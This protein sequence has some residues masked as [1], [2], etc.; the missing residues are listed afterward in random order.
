MNITNPYR[1]TGANAGPMLGRENTFRAIV[2]HLTKAT[3]DHLSVVGP[4]RYGKTVILRELART[5]AVSNEHYLAAAYMDLRHGTPQSDADF[6]KRLAQSVKE[7]LLNSRGDLVEYLVDDDDSLGELLQY[8]FEELQKSSS[9]L[10]LVMDGFDYL[11]LGDGI[12]PNLLDQMRAFAQMSSVRLVTGSRDRLREL[13]KTE[14]SRTSEFWRIFYDPP[15]EIGCLEERDWEHFLGSFGSRGIKIQ[16][17]AL[18]ELTNWSGGIPVLAGMLAD[19]LFEM[20]AEGREVSPDDVNRV[21]ADVLETRNDHIADLWDDCSADIQGFV[22]DLAHSDILASECVPHQRR[23]LL[24]RGFAQETSGKLKLSS[25]LIGEYSKLQGGGV[26][27]IRRLFGD[28]G[29]YSRNIKGL[30]ELRLAQ[31]E[32]GDRELLG[33]VKR[34]VKDLQPEP[35]FSVVWARSIA[36]RALDIVWRA[37]LAEDRKLPDKWVNELKFNGVP[38]QNYLDPGNR[39]LNDRGKQCGLLRCLTGGKV[40]TRVVG[41]M[42]Q[43]VSKPTFLLVDHIQSVGNYGQHKA[44]DVPLGFAS[45][46]CFAAVELCELLASDLKGPQTSST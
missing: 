31:I 13:C 38:V 26:T 42:T 41:R 18:T 32:G 22:T 45:A 27:N 3:P 28:S 46:V 7:S 20:T 43:F 34:A 23:E 12:S 4:K 2:R 44:G 16:K 9:K 37:E 14:E 1:V 10:L 30:L 15:I 24:L 36:E 40:G 25:R 5:F 21:A 39:V 11:P 6:R 33:F 35:E 17:G 19:R 8:V 29:G